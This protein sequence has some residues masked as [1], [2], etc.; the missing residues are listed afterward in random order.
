[1]KL[2]DFL[3]PPFHSLC[4]LGKA[5]ILASIGK[6]ELETGKGKFRS[7]HSLSSPSIVFLIQIQFDY[8]IFTFE[9][10]LYNAKINDKEYT[11]F[12]TQ[13]FMLLAQQSSAE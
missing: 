11:F 10:N 13:S 1:M 12:G 8:L 9:F 6:P 3:F 2:I 4:I 7:S 5:C